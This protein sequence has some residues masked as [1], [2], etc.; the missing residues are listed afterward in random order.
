MPA[1]ARGSPPALRQ[2]SWRRCVSYQKCCHPECERRISPTCV[3]SSAF[4]R[5]L[6]RRG[7]LG[8]TLLLCFFL[9]P[10]REN[11]HFAFWCNP[12]AQLP[13]PLLRQRLEP[14]ECVARS[15]CERPEGQA[16]AQPAVDF[17]ASE[18]ALFPS[19]DRHVGPR[20]DFLPREK[21]FRYP[22]ECRV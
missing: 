9:L 12:R 22:C 15:F 16:F 6:G 20:L 13:L 18:P 3:T 19:P 8:M 1:R 11:L 2:R 10:R 5:S 21:I 14:G 17:R 4:V 7:D